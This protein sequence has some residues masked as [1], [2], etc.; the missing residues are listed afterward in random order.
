MAKEWR[1]KTFT[2]E[3]TLLGLS[4]ENLVRQV[5]DFLNVKGLRPGEFHLI[6]STTDALDTEAESDEITIIYW[7]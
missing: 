2:R 4:H 3:R 6:P 1:S 5:L 7:G